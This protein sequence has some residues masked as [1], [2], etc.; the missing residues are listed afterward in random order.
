MSEENT[1]P[2]PEQIA[3]YNR[4]RVARQEEQK[5][6]IPILKTDKEYLNLLADIDEAILRREVA[7]HRLANMNAPPEADK[8]KDGEE[9]K[10]SDIKE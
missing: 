4:A 3:A 8:E 9:K 6:Q 2:T 1:Q 10:E 7:R 5:K